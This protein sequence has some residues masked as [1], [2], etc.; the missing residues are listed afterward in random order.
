MNKRAKGQRI[1]RLAVKQLEDEGYLVYRV[2]GTTKFNK[3]NDIF[4]LFD[5][6]AIQRIM[7]DTKHKFIQVKSNKKPNLNLFEE[8]TRYYKDNDVSIEVWVH[9]DRKGFKKYIL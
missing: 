1:E 6:Y 5:I 9:K 8:F 7:H 3:E 2:K 4:G